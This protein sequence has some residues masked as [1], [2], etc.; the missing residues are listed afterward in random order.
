LRSPHH[1]QARKLF[2]DLDTSS[3]SVPT[4]HG[5][6]ISKTKPALDDPPHK[7]EHK[8]KKIVVKPTPKAAPRAHKVVHSELGA[9]VD[10]ARQ[11]AAEK[12]KLYQEMESLKQRINR[13]FAK[14]YLFVRMQKLKRRITDISSQQAI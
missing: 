10:G 7:V 12:A 11:L 14:P 5:G 2:A 9:S 6:W 4:A 8:A 13:P 1:P 3:E